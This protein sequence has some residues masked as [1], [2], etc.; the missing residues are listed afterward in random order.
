MA[1]KKRGNRWYFDFMVRRTRYRGAIPEART[2]H[3][4][5]QAEARIRSDVFEGKYGQGKSISLKGFIEQIYLPWAESSKLSVQ[6]D[7]Y[8]IQAI[9]DYFGDMPMRNVSQIQVEKFKNELVVKP[10]RKKT[11]RKPATVN[12][13]LATLSRVFSLAREY[14]YINTNL[15]SRVRRLREDNLRVRYLSE[16]EQSR[17]LNALT[18]SREWL[19]PVVIFALNSG[20]RLGEITGLCWSQVGFER[21]VISVRRTK[22]G[23]DRFVPIN[24]EAHD[25]L[26][27]LYRMRKGERVFIEAS[28][29]DKNTIS[30]TF[31][32]VVERAGIEDF[33]FH[34]LRHT[35]GTRMGEAGA[36]L[37]TI[38]AVLGHSDLSMAARYTHPTDR[39]VGKAVEYLSGWQQKNCHKIA[40]IDRERKREAAS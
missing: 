13:I 26:T 9:V 10:T 20:M 32:R 25:L 22:T 16:E 21:E 29:R 7:R 34:D 39:G 15:A 24:A 17:L 35:A 36:G 3:Q 38:A 30:T 40:T 4:A 12:R 2:I 33:H 14:G 19:R 27:D 23:K 5:K 11:A 18:G 37:V 31:A 1:V 6:T 28:C 8:H